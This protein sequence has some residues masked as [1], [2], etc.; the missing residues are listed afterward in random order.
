MAVYVDS[1]GIQWRGRSWCHLVADSLDELHAFA[2]QLGLKRHWFQERSYYP[3]YDVTMSVRDKA[4]R[5]GAI[6]ADRETIIT[7]CKLMRSE[8]LHLRS[9]QSRTVDA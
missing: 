5:I 7:R 1:E 3:H 4:I 9:L 2:A 8:M 6:D